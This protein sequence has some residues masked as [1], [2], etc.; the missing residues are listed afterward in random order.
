MGAELF[1]SIHPTDIK[2]KF[3]S[4][5][6]IDF[7]DLESESYKT[8]SVLGSNN[9][10]KRNMFTFSTLIIDLPFIKLNIEIINKDR[11]LFV[12]YGDKKIERIFLDES[13]TFI[14]MDDIKNN[15]NP[16][17][18]DDR[19]P[20]GYCDYTECRFRSIWLLKDPLKEGVGLNTICLDSYIDYVIDYKDYIETNIEEITIQSDDGKA[21]GESILEFYRVIYKN[22]DKWEMVDGLKNLGINRPLH[23]RV[24]AE[25]K[26]THL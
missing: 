19:N 10:Q 18:E 17:Y 13:Q 4:V 11:C 5:K 24:R 23:L 21:Y 1:N 12:S 16:I 15:H 25:F 20:T 3:K 6:K 22:N 7:K 14:T 2:V 9:R 8:L 26:H